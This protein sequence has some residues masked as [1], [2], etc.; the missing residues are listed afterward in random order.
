MFC[1]SAAGG[2]PKP[3]QRVEGEL[4]RVGQ[5][6][7]YGGMGT[8]FIYHIDNG[9][10]ISSRNVSNRLGHITVREDGRYQSNALVRG[11]GVGS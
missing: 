6:N 7:G 9:L 10:G 1:G 2:H 11:K 5:P 8:C 3:N 4:V